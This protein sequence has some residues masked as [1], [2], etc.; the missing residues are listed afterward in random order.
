MILTTSII[1]STIVSL[2]FNKLKA[3]VSENVTSAIKIK[4]NKIIVF[5]ITG[6][7]TQITKTIIDTLIIANAN[8]YTLGELLGS[9]LHELR[10]EVR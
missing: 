3:T 9:K 1:T 8:D 6:L 2:L 4:N 7:S 10:K 5:K